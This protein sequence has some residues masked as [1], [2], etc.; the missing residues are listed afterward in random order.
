MAW[1]II[2]LKD[3]GVPVWLAWSGVQPPDLCAGRDLNCL[4]ENRVEKAICAK[5][6]HFQSK[7]HFFH[8]FLI[9]MAIEMLWSEGTLCPCLHSRA[10]PKPSG[11]S[12]EVHKGVSTCWR[13][14]QT[15]SAAWLQGATSYPLSGTGLLIWAMEREVTKMLSYLLWHWCLLSVRLYNRVHRGPLTVY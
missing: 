15:R 7:E 8:C 9:Q 5:S 12:N 6:S 14:A 2:E 10:D 3:T 11:E 1:P 13:R 4:A